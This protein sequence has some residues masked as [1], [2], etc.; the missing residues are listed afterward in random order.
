MLLKKKLEKNS[1]ISI[2]L[3]SGEEIIAKLI[4]NEK[5]EIVISKPLM[6]M[7]TQNGG[8][9]FMPYMLGAEEKAELTLNN[10]AIIFMT[11][12][13]SELKNAYISN[14]SGIIPAGS[15]NVKEGSIIK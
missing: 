8:A 12:T 5:D 9:A 15:D 13:R 14:T 3:I 10:N 11:L 2:K 6:I 7:L 1:I 4:S